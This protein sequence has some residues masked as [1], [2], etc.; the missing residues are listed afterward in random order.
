MLNL[1][2][3]G[4]YLKTLSICSVWLIKILKISALGKALCHGWMS[5]GTSI[6]GCDRSKCIACG[7]AKGFASAYLGSLVVGF[8]SGKAGSVSFF[9]TVCVEVCL[10]V[11]EYWKAF[12]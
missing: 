7:S 3:V 2:L 4:E 11:R 5:V 6:C 12:G 9:G 1:D 8:M 10:P